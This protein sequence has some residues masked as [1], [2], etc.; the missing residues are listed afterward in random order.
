VG[1]CKIQ[2]GLPVPMFNPSYNK[3]GPS[4]QTMKQTD[5]QVIKIIH[6]HLDLSAATKTVFK[7]SYIYHIAEFG[8]HPHLLNNHPQCEAEDATA[9]Y[10]VSLILQ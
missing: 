9:G 5:S 8:C 7:H 2:V 1:D 6:L 4:R 10:I 3:M